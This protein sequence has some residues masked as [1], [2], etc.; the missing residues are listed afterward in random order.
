MHG[1]VQNVMFPGGSLLPEVI[2]LVFYL[3]VSVCVLG[4]RLSF[5]M[6]STKAQHLGLTE[7]TKMSKSSTQSCVGDRHT[8]R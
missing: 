6:L 5:G 4:A 8:H 2:F 1:F 3:R 7:G